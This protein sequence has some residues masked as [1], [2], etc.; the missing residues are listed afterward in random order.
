MSAPTGPR[1]GDSPLQLHHIPYSFDPQDADASCLRLV[2]QLSCEWKSEGRHVKFKRFTD[3]ITNTLIK[4]SQ[5]RPGQSEA[6]ADQEAVLIR[7]YGSGT[8]FI[9][10]REKE[11]RAHN[12]LAAMG[13]AAPL[14]ARFEN[15]F[16][17]RFIPGDICEPQDFHHPET[18]RQIAKMLG[19][20]HG[21]LPISVLT[22]TPK[23]GDAEVPEKHAALSKD[24]KQI[25]PIPN[26][27]RNAQDWIGLLPA[28]T[29]ELKKRNELFKREL[30]WLSEKFSNTPGLDGRDYVFSHTD[31]LCANVILEGAT[32]DNPAQRPVT[33]IDYEYA[34]TAPAA[35]DV[36]NFFAEWAGP[37]G[38]LSWMPSRS[39]RLDFIE[40]YVG[41]FRQYSSISD[42]AHEINVKNDVAQVYQQVELFRGL[43]GFYWGIW[44]LIQ[45]SISDIDFDYTGYA[46]RRHSEYWGWKAEYDGSREREGKEMT[47]REKKWAEE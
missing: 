30:A 28:D 14:L 47:V 25:P 7:A 12:L 32:D 20:W 5:Q 42:P 46:E 45:A 3:G 17:C 1:A 15:G 34:T 11:V 13:L 23:P 10:D 4:V 9:I 31:L 40:H 41:S 16:M 33:F 27:W 6:D 8:D 39:Q 29:D 24:G 26:I 22:T 43:P 38:E 21:S 44:A 35:F 37:D 36:A 2:H 19:Q 18:Y